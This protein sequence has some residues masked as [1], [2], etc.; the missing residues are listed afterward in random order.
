[1]CD[2]LTS[3][4]VQYRLLKSNEMLFIGFY[5]TLLVDPSVRAFTQMSM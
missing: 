4:M 5:C 2:V 3:K 1:M